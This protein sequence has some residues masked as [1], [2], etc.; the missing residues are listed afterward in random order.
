LGLAAGAVL[1]IAAC[2]TPGQVT[3]PENPPATN[4]RIDASETSRSDVI[5]AD[6]LS[7]IGSELEL[8]AL[9]HGAV[10]VDLFSSGTGATANLFD[11]HVAAEGA[12][13]PARERKLQ[14]TVEPVMEQIM[15][16]WPEVE[17][18]LPPDGTDI[19]GQLD[20]LAEYFAQHPE[21]P[22]RGLILTDGVQTTG[23]LTTNNE[24]FTEAVATDLAERVAVP[25]LT[26]AE[27]TIA[28][29]GR[30]AAGDPPPSDYVSAL[31]TFYRVVCER[32]GAQCLIVTDL[33]SDRTSGRPGAETS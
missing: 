8:T 7:T 14:A 15:A 4:I 25:D 13:M 22:H 27:I 17:A 11:G 12:T 20:L 2:S 6:H 24:A 9:C 18:S 21:A 1:T 10:S 3:C 28:G 33:A 19:I 31:K 32:T 23:S 29:I 5:R 30:V 16:G 26:G